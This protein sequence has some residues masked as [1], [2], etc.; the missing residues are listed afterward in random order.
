MLGPM[1]VRHYIQFH[2]EELAKRSAPVC[3]QACRKPQASP[4]RARRRRG[5][6]RGLPVSRSDLFQDQFLKRQI[7]HR[8]AQMRILPKVAL[9]N[10]RQEAGRSIFV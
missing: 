1:P 3:W 4:W 5:G 6:E 9:I 7:R 10:R 2:A 8:L